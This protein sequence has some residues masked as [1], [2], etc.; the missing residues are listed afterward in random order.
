MTEFIESEKSAHSVAALCRALEVPE[1]LVYEN[2]HRKPSKRKQEDERLG[3]LIRVEFA[4]HRNTYG[5]PRITDELREQGEHV[6]QKRVA[7]LMR[8]NGLDARPKPKFVCTTNSAH[9]RGYS[10]NLL[11]RNFDVIAPNCVWVGDITYVPTVQGWLYLATMVDL[12]ARRI[13]GYALSDRIDDD[14]TLEALRRAIDL[15]NPPHGLIHHTDR[16][17]QYASHDY[18]ALLRGNGIT[19]SMSRKA[20][21]FDNAVA[22]SVF[23]T[24]EKDVIL[25]HRFATRDQARKTLIDYIENFYNPIRKHSYN[26]QLSP[27]K[28]E[29]IYYQNLQI[30]VAA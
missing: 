1:S 6:S 3:K 26:D 14:L 10:P 7:R 15:R 8:E 9:E 25:R 28:A 30:A 12:F 11:E 27:A 4:N 29:N 16:G 17:S 24:I 18:R 23:A 19:Q 5:S 13:V 22:E 2:R 20:D 21:C